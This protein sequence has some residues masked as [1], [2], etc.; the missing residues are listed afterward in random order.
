MHHWGEPK[1]W[2]IINK[3]YNDAMIELG[4]SIF[5]NNWPAKAKGSKP[6]CTAPFSHIAYFISPLELKSASIPANYNK[7]TQNDVVFI[8]DVMIIEKI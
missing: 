7:Q 4:K 3:V 8:L 1:Q 2:I 6:T 5:R